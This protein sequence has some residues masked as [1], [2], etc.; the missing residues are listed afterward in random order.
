ML[1]WIVSNRN[2]LSNTSSLWHTKIYSHSDFSV[3]IHSVSFV[4]I[5]NWRK[6]K[7]LCKTCSTTVNSSICEPWIVVCTFTHSLNSLMWNYAESI[8][9]FLSNARATAKRDFSVDCFFSLLIF[10]APLQRRM[11]LYF[12]FFFITSDC[13]I[14]I[15]RW[16]SETSRRHTK[17]PRLLKQ[18]TLSWQIIVL[19]Y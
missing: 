19:N 6:K 8:F 2:S 12:V 13:T 1:S 14:D 10:V 11:S 16:I 15:L 3:R 5:D 9:G 4:S 18:F 7:L 17:R